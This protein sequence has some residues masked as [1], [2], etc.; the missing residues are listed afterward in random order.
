MSSV[1]FSDRFDK[2]FNFFLGSMPLLALIFQIF[3]QD[4]ITSNFPEVTNFLGIGVITI[5]FAVMSSFTVGLAMISTSSFSDG[6]SVQGFFLLLLMVISTIITF[7]IFKWIIQS[8]QS[9]P[10]TSFRKANLTDADFSH[11][12]VQNRDFSLA[13]INWSLYF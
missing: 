4:S 2:I 7:R 8:I 6:S 3:I 1:L 9:N 11:S 10:G 12:E 5:L 13:I